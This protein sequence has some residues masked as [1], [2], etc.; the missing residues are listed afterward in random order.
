MKILIAEDDPVTSRILEALLSKWGYAPKMTQDGLEAWNAIQGPEPPNLVVSDWMMPGMDGVELCRRIRARNAAE[1][2]YFVILTAKGTKGDL[3][4]AL[5]A[6]VDDYILKPFDPNELRYRVRIGQ[7]IIELERR[8]LDLSKT[9]PLTGVLNRRAFLERLGAEIARSDREGDCLTLVMLDLDHFKSINDV[10]GHQK[11]DE[12]LITLCSEIRKCTRP[13]DFIGRYGGDEFI[14]C[15]IN[16]TPEQSVRI[17]ERLL[18][19]IRNIRFPL[20]GPGGG[21]Q[22]TASMGAAVRLARSGT[23]IAELIQR[24]DDALYAAKKMGRNRVS[25]I[26]PVSPALEPLGEDHETS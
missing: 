5:E 6:G 9:D 8:I 13:Y 2:V 17:S 3:Y 18:E 23:D 20:S 1:Y 19:E 12:V 26:G 24:A 16:E 11:G 4:L 21:I 7:R 22:V 25:L 15:L 14:M 10:N